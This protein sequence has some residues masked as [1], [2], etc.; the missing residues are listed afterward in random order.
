MIDVRLA[1]RDQPCMIMVLT[2]EMMGSSS[3]RIK[4]GCRSRGRLVQ[5]MPEARAFDVLDRIGFQDLQQS[6]ADVLYWEGVPDG[7]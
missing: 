5:P 6:A 1:A 4:V 7:R 2:S 3:A